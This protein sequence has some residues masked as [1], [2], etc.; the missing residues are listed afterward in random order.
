MNCLDNSIFIDQSKIED[1]L[2]QCQMSGQV[3]NNPHIDPCGHT[4]CLGC[5]KEAIRV[6]QRCPISRLELHENSLKPNDVI[7]SFIKMLQIS[8][9]N[10]NRSCPWK[11]EVDSLEMHLLNCDEELVNCPHKCSATFRRICLPDHDKI[12]PNKKFKCD[13]C[14]ADVRCSQLEY[15]REICFGRSLICNMGCGSTII[16]RDYSKHTNGDCPNQT[17]YCKFIKIGCLFVST[18]WGLQHH[19]EK[20]KIFHLKLENKTINY[21]RQ[22][23]LKRLY[24]LSDEMLSEEPDKCVIEPLKSSPYKRVPLLTIDIFKLPSFVIYQQSSRKLVNNCDED[25]WVVTF[26]DRDLLVFENVVITI[27][28]VNPDIEDFSIAVGFVDAKVLGNI[29]NIDQD[30]NLENI[31]KSQICLLKDRENE[32]IGTRI[33][34][35]ENHV[36][37]FYVDIGSGKG[38]IQNLSTQKKF[39]LKLPSEWDGDLPVVV[40]GSQAAFCC[41]ISIR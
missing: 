9:V 30:T 21:Q 19:Y 20:C 8:C 35:C 28:K 40:V 16:K 5:F 3:L 7:S 22:R 18:K 24:K 26:F 29:R 23:F 1:E 14:S 41:N 13:L 34:F 6:S 10:S 39:K 33:N 15:H 32:E 27:V 37:L 36:L 11:G 4:L 31:P 17:N 38:V 25:K 2:L 12:C